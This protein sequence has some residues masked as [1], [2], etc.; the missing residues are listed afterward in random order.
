M[1]GI[2]YLLTFTILYTAFVMTFRP[3]GIDTISER[4]WMW[5][6]NDPVGSIIV[7]VS[8]VVYFS[9]HFFGRGK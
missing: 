1:L 9:Y 8:V 3:P 4:V 7:W 6:K 5:V 2:L